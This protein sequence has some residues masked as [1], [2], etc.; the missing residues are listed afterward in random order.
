M[1]AVFN[2]LKK[3]IDAGYVKPGGAG[4]QFTAAQ[5]QWS[6]AAGLH[7]LPVGRLDRE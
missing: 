2:G 1:Q 4:T 5:S 7:P 3:I 6:D